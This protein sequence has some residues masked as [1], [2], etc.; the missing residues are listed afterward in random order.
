MVLRNAPRRI[1]QCELPVLGPR[2]LFRR[3]LVIDFDT[4][5]PPSTPISQLHPEPSSLHPERALSLRDPDDGG[6]LGSSSTD[7]DARCALAADASDGE[8]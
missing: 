6:V 3:A 1:L 4:S 5:T 7:L 8:P 2:E